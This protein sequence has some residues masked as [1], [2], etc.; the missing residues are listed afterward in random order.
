MGY[1][2]TWTGSI[3]IEPPVAEEH[4]SAF[5]RLVGETAHRGRCGWTFPRATQA[6][7][8]YRLWNMSEMADSSR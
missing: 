6:L 3:R 4:M 1:S 2:R 7:S 5:E 8:D